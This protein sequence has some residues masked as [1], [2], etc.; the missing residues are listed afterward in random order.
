MCLTSYALLPKHLTTNVKYLY[1]HSEHI[2][3]EFVRQQAVVVFDAHFKVLKFIT[4]YPRTSYTDCHF[5]VLTKICSPILCLC[6]Y[7]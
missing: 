4:N 1:E 6:V 7:Y 5:L 2:E 3:T